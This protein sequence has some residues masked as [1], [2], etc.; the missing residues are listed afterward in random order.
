MNAYGAKTSEAG[1]YSDV[2]METVRKGLT[3]LPELAGSLANVTGIA[4]LGK[5]PIETLASAIAA[6]TATGIPTEQAITGMKNVIANIIKPTKE[7]SDMA[8]GLGIEFSAAA[9]KTKGL[10][11]VLWDAWRATKGNSEQMNTLFGS[12]RGLNAA[13]VL[14]SDASGR[15]RDILKDMGNVAGTTETAYKKMEGSFTLTTQN[16]KNNIDVLLIDVGSRLLGTYSQMG[17]GLSDVFKGFKVAVDSGAF[18]PLFKAFDAMSLSVSAYIAK[19]GAALPEALKD[20]D[21]SSLIA[22]FG[23]LGDALSNLFNADLTN[24]KELHNV[25]QSIVDVIA[26]LIRI[27]TGMV[28]AFKPMASAIAEFFVALG[29]GDEESQKTLGTLMALSKAVEMAGLG[30]AAALFAIDQYKI[31]ITGMFSVIGGGVQILWNGAQLIADSIQAL[32]VILEGALLQFVKTASLGLATLIPG[33]NDLVATVEASGKKVGQSI[34][35]DGED[36]GRGLDKMLKGFNELAAGATAATPKIKAAGDTFSEIPAEK[37]MSLDISNMI[38]N[39]GKAAIEM[40][41]VSDRNVKLGVEVDLPQLETVKKLVLETLPDGTRTIHEV[42]VDIPKL[43]AAKS[44]VEKA[45]PDARKV[46]IQLETARVKQQADVIQKAIEWKGKIDIAEIEAGAKVILAMFTSVNLGIKD[47]GDLMSSMF[48]A[49]SKAMGPERSFIEQQI[50]Q[51]EARRSETFKLQ[52]YLIEQQTKLLEMKIKAM[53][54]SGRMI[55]IK[56]DGLK[57]HLEMIL[58][59]VLEACQ[60]R[61]NESASEFLLGVG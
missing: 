22:A 25:L 59:E 27:T 60:I 28:E 35:Q 39:A 57:P 10:E 56:A 32:F 53:E 44:T 38:T 6:L 34:M 5:V 8:A 58:W 52:K 45:I 3:T 7:A 13:T 15:F 31:S 61:A 4:A 51:E 54:G 2:F 16:I 49:L 11:T 42:Y 30:F 43:D 41:R 24:P 14:A 1:H 33:F 20:L 37:S 19:I 9:L 46:E 26:G 47:T 23:G 18:D 48:S 21:F 29:K 17:A 36:A 50:K 40:S 55:E 12:I